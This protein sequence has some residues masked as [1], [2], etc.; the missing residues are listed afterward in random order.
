MTYAEAQSELD[1]LLGDS[2]D[3]TFTPEEKQR[4]LTEAWRDRYLVT[5]TTTTYTYDTTINTY[6]IPSTMT[7]VTNVGYYTS[8]TWSK[9]LDSGAWEVIGSDLVIDNDYRYVIPSG[10]TLDVRGNYKLTT[11]DEVTDANQIEYVLTLAHYNTLKL[12]GAKKTNRF[13]KNDV[14]MNEIIAVRRD[15]E[16]EIRGLRQGLQ[17]AYE[18]I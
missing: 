8:D 3:F 2:D 16:A 17:R 5:P 1:I 15:L 6:A 12:L 14:T 13:V 18:R 10:A 11:S 9:P 7:T 4:A